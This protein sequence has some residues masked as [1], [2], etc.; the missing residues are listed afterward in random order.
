MIEGADFF[1]RLI[2]FPAGANCNGMLMPNPDGTWSV[3]INARAGR[4][5][6]R[7]AALH[8]LAHI[9]RGDLDGEKRIEDVEDAL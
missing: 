7:K 9:E 8:E 2:P 6:Q 3:Y 4:K 1:I 5:A